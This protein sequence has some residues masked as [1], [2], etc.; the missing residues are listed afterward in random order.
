VCKIS[1]YAREPNAYNFYAAQ[2]TSALARTRDHIP[3]GAR[4]VNIIIELLRTYVFRVCHYN[5]IVVVVVVVVVRADGP[6][7]RA[8]PGK[9]FGRRPNLTGFRSP[10]FGFSLKKKN[11][12][13]Y[14]DNNRARCARLVVAVNGRIII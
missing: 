13:R 7:E 9:R 2:T 3:G 1:L 5:N 4:G 8:E 12:I 14:D 6:E 11:K 10:P